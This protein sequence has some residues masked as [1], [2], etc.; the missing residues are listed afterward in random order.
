[1]KHVKKMTFK[2]LCQLVHIANLIL[3]YG[4]PWIVM[5]TKGKEGKKKAQIDKLLIKL[6]Q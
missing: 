4:P 2:I 3:Q 6:L 1:M 5:W